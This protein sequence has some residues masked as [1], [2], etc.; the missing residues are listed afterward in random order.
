MI[1]S[2]PKVILGMSGGVDSSV[3]AL[4]LQQQG[5]EVIGMFMHC[6]VDEQKRWPTSI[7]WK[8]EEQHIK[9]VCKQ[10][11]IKFI[12]KDCGA[13]YEKKVISKM[14][15]SYKKGLTPNPDILCNNVG[16]FPLLLKVAKEQGAKYI[17]TGH[18][19]QVKH[20]KKNG[21]ELHQGVDQNKDQSYFL[22]G[23]GNSYFKKCLFPIGKY[24]KDQ[25][26]K[27][28]KKAGFKNWDKRGSRGICYLG[29][30]DMKDFLHSRIKEKQGNIIDQNND[31]IGTHPGTTFFTI[32]EKIT[33]GKGSELNKLGRKEYSSTKLFVSKKD[34]KNNIHIAPEN[35]PNL[36]TKKLAIIG[37]KT[38]NKKEN[39][40][41]KKIHLRIRHLGEMIPA[42]IVKENN[43]YIAKLKKPVQGIAPGQFAVI[44]DK[45]RLVGGGEIR[46]INQD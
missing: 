31:I 27:I 20:T 33:S 10:L 43:K 38:I 45:T 39:I 25:V 17:A 34:K 3:A 29:K 14:F 18:Y 26:R 15:D 19:A 5:Y 42:K 9:D 13:G 7:S 24:T 16:K 41:N 35:H 32:G 40:E 4:L 46:L 6:D 21:V 1:K 22:I 30:I 44:Y 12:T 23:L 36:A 37:L 2:K 8:E 28:A 11:G